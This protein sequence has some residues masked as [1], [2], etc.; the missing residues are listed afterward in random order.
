VKSASPPPPAYPDAVYSNIVL[1]G[2]KQG[3]EKKGV[4]ERS[5][6]ASSFMDWTGLEYV[7]RIYIGR[8]LSCR[9]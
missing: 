4:E 1:D 2:G 3:K 9:A 6:N 5:S 7:K 8:K